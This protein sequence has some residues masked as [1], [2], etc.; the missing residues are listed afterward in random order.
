[1]LPCCGMMQGCPGCCRLLWPAPTAAPAA[2][3]LE[4]MECNLVVG[5]PREAPPH[6]VR[7][8]AP[9]RNPTE[10]TTPDRWCPL[11]VRFDV[12]VQEEYV[13]APDSTLGTSVTWYMDVSEYLRVSLAIALGGHVL[14][15]GAVVWYAAVRFVDNDRNAAWVLARRAQV[16]T[17]RI[18][19]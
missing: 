13:S 1:M 12:R 8:L 11:T 16:V 17:R 4:Y 5:M 2:N 19:T 7:P 15:K 9:S 3:I 10:H 14:D 6:K 18:T